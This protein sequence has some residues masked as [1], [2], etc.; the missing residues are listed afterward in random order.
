MT[1]FCETDYKMTKVNPVAKTTAITDLNLQ[2]EESLRNNT[3][4]DTIFFDLQEA[5]RV[6]GATTS[7]LNLFEVG[8][9]GNLPSL[10]QSFLY[11]LSL[12]HI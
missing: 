5:F 6:C 9:R 10:L 3:N 4:F 7:A 8:L 1:K 12:I 11:D 2:I